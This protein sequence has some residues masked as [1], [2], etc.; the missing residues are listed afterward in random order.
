MYPP[1]NRQDPR[2]WE[3]P[4]DEI[5]DESGLPMEPNSWGEYDFDDDDDD[6]DYEED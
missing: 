2:N 3:K 1:I 5:L 4:F 6:V